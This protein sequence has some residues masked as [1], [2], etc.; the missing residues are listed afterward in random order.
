MDSSRDSS[1][2]FVSSSFRTRVFAD[3]LQP[4]LQP[5]L[6]LLELPHARLRLLTPRSGSKQVSRAATQGSL[7]SHRLFGV[8]LLLALLFLPRT[9]LTSRHLSVSAVQGLVA[10]QAPLTLLQEHLAQR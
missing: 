10:Q 6:C 4:G 3:G 5:G 8:R 1:L 7:L 9:A 2:D